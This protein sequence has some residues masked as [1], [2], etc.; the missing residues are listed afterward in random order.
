MKQVVQLSANTRGKYFICLYDSYTFNIIRQR[1][2]KVTLKMS[3]KRFLFKYRKRNGWLS[4]KISLVKVI[5]NHVYINP[6]TETY[7]Q[8]YWDYIIYTCQSYISMFSPHRFLLRNLFVSFGLLSVS[9][10]AS[11][12]ITLQTKFQ[13]TAWLSRRLLTLSMPLAQICTK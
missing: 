4:F 2:D 8:C 13:I 9:G 5:G 1:I 10:T 12:C 6:H 7:Y 11:V 3:S